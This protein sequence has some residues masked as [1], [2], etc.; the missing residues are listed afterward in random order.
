MPPQT[1]R[2]HE[3]GGYEILEK[4]GQGGMGT[5]FKARQKSLNRI[6]ALKILPLSVA[7]NALYIERFQREARASAKFNHPNIVQG[8]DVARD[9][10]SGLWYFAME[11]VDGPSLKQV[12]AEQKVLPEERALKLVR[13]L[14]RALECIAAHGM[15][16]RDIK[17]DNILLTRHGESKLAD[18]GLAKQ[19]H[20]DASVTQSG[21]TVGTPHYMAPEQIRGQAHEIDIRTDI[22][23]LGG[24]FFHLVTGRLPY[25]GESSAVIMS[26]HL[27]EPPPQARAANPR[28]SEGCSRLIEWMMQKDKEQRIQSPA[29][30]LKQIDKVL[31]QEPVRNPKLEIRNPKEKDNLQ[32]TK[33]RWISS[34]GFWICALL[35]LATGM[36]FVLNAKKPPETTRNN[37][38]AA[39]TVGRAVSP[40]LPS[41]T[42]KPAPLVATPLP[43]QA[44]QPAP[45]VATPA[46]PPKA[47]G[48]RELFRDIQELER[49][50]PE[51]YDEILAQYRRVTQA[52]KKAEH[53]P[54]LDELLNDAIAAVVA[55]RAAAAETAWKMLEE[56]INA[57]VAA[58]NY[59][60]A[61]TACETLPQSLAKAL[62][63][64]AAARA[65]LLHQ[66]AEGKIK[67]VAARVEE[68][69]ANAEP[70]DGLKA[71]A[72]AEKLS[73]APMKRM[74]EDLKKR[75]QEGLA[76]EPELKQRKAKRI[77]EK[78]LE[79]LLRRFD[80]A[81]LEAGDLQAAKNVA[82]E[83]A[84]DPALAPIAA[85]ARAMGELCAGFDELAKRSK[86]A[87]ANLVGQKV[88]LE[89]KGS[90]HS[91]TV[92]KIEDGTVFLKIEYAPGAEA[93]KQIKVADLSEEQRKIFSGHVTPQT[94]SQDVA[95]AVA[96]MPKGKEDLKAAG[97]LLALAG[98]FP[99][100]QHYGRL[101]E[102]LRQ[103]AARAEAETKAA[104]AWVELDL[105]AAKP[106]L[107]E[108][109]ATAL[110]N[111]VLSFE[112][113]FGATQ[114]A[115]TVKDKLAA[116]KERAAQ[117][118]ASNAIQNGGFESGALDPW[119]SLVAE[120][121][122]GQ[123]EVVKAEAHGGKCAALLR[124]QNKGGLQQ[125]LSVEPGADYR[126]SAWMKLVKG[127]VV[128]SS[129]R[130][131]LSG[132]KNKP[133]ISIS[134]DFLQNL[135]PGVWNLVEGAAR[136]GGAKAT[137]TI[138]IVSPGPVELL[139][140]DVQMLKIPAAPPK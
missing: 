43:S 119:R 41:Q 120:K 76:N 36:F 58:G 55:R 42:G 137:L 90:K 56:K 64:R 6:V 136:A 80:Q 103:E 97:E 28:V 109:E 27:T 134:N 74:V 128:L 114:Y 71:L 108:T 88:E 9:P 78:R 57:A 44:G 12:L 115:A 29:E 54:H 50:H 5:V 105:R 19:A 15:V 107:S 111:K 102:E 66:E 86:E 122:G 69:L 4:I 96:K 11:Y 118:G 47:Q 83:A 139:V 33:H 45:L 106:N 93:K 23:A 63:E 132:E 101:L 110:L 92:E 53:D 133:S 140:D 124:V 121:K 135:K 131:I 26:K 82:S 138:H 48:P 51:A 2:L 84:R 95:V 10:V 100:A 72:D 21:T 8:I 60:A 7:R 31:R 104:A 75:L 91:G 126:F 46:P 123:C 70:A 39:H 127:D 22:Y 17:P 37:N 85:Q 16:H 89:A 59:D 13:E 14:A 24:T 112:T 113:Q 116:I 65:R 98:D 130:I 87:L 77:A 79:E 38:L 94:N 34:F 73:Y 68:C 49:A 18:L 35:A 20:D 40:P 129:S 62:E 117:V 99:L 25:S 3:I 1:A 52:A 81:L 67:A 125:D 32:T 30:L 61:L